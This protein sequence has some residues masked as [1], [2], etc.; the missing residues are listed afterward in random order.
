MPA[1]IAHL[2]AQHVAVAV[3]PRH[4][5]SQSDMRATKT[6]SSA[7][8]FQRKDAARSLFL[9]LK[10]ND[11]PVF[12]S[13]IVVTDRT[14]LDSQLHNTIKNFLQVGAT[15]GH[16]EGSGDLRRFIQAGRKLLFRPSRSFPG[17]SKTLGA[18]IAA[19]RSRSLSTKRIPARAGRPP[20]R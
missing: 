12:E 3:S 5:V 14:I 6:A 17:F 4:I 8:S 1:L 20:P 19:R 16:A 11:V 10:R 9:G 18:C 7:A 2:W 13:V 15:V